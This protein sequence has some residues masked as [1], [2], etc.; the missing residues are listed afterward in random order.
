MYFGEPINYR[1]KDLLK[2]LEYLP[3]VFKNLDTTMRV[4]DS[5]REGWTHELIARVIDL[6]AMWLGSNA[7]YDLY[8]GLNWVGC[9]EY[10]M[11]KTAIC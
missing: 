5:P 2:G 4:F 7:G 9:S 3:L 8:L 10:E 1:K 6:F 11:A